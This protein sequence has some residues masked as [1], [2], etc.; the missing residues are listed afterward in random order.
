MTNEQ[1]EVEELANHLTEV[2]FRNFQ[3]DD[4]LAKAILSWG[5]RKSPDAGLVG[6]DEKQFKIKLYGVMSL[7]YLKHKSL[8]KIEDMSDDLDMYWNICSKFSI[9]AQSVK[10]PEKNDNLEQA[11]KELECDSPELNQIIGWN[12]CIEEFKKINPGVK[13]EL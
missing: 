2:E 5:Y 11:H 1:K 13:E 9:P 7:F 12:A 6:L 10:F 8:P 3:R 4:S